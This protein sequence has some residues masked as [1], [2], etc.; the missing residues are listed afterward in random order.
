M[1]TPILLPV[2]DWRL[3]AHHVCR[4]AD[5]EEG[6][7]FVLDM[8]SLATQPFTGCPKHGAM[9]RGYEWHLSMYGMMLLEQL[10]HQLDGS[11][12]QSDPTYKDAHHRYVVAAQQRFVRAEKTSEP[13]WFGE[14]FLHESHQ[15]WLLKRDYAR[16][17]H[18]YPKTPD[19]LPLVWPPH[20]PEKRRV[21]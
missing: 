17:R 11:R 14:G 13:W 7:Q 21:L 16:Y 20:E 3:S 15:S 19:C 5:G 8:V 2:P 1:S 18:Y 4:S 6:V 10:D 9:W 12:Y